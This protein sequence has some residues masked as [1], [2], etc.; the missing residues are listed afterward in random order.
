MT[1]LRELSVELMHGHCQDISPVV[2]GHLFLIVRPHLITHRAIECLV[3]KVQGNSN[4]QNKSY[5]P[6]LSR[7]SLDFVDGTKIVIV[8]VLR[9]DDEG[10]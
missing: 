2:A 3:G 5:T 4:P 6:M 1:S 7:A 9:L 8:A 10:L